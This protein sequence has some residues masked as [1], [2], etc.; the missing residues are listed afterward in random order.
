MPNARAA[1]ADSAPDVTRTLDRRTRPEPFGAPHVFVLV[2]IAGDDPAVVH[3]IVAADTIVGRGDEAQFS[4][5]D[6]QVSK[7]HCR[8]RVEGSVCTL[9]DL[10][11]RNGTTVNGRR[12]TAN[13]AQRLRHLDEIEVGSSR[14]LLLAGR[15]R[16]SS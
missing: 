16:P 6:E 1:A 4:I 14:L 13:G 9:Y 11:S 3:R 2:V 10:G 7:K 12:L 5:E 15:F 8:I